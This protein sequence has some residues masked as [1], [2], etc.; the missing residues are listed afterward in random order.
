MAFQRTTSADFD[1]IFLLLPS[2]NSV[3]PDNFFVNHRVTKNLEVIGNVLAA[4]QVV[5][6]IQPD[7]FRSSQNHLKQF[8]I[9][10]C[11]VKILNFRFLSNFSQ[12]TDLSIKKSVNF[13]TFNL[14][15]LPNLISLSILNCTG[16][17]QWTVFP[18]FVKG[19]E[20][21]DLECN[22]LN[23]ETTEQ[24]LRYI[25]TGPS[26]VSLTNI[27]LSRNALT[28]IPRQLKSFANIKNMFFNDQREPGFGSLSYL[29]PLIHVEIYIDLSSCNITS[30]QPDA[31]KGLFP[32]SYINKPM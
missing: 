14:P 17:N 18:N 4:E 32:A 15:P 28:R 26:N 24:L 27:R 23:D 30:I 9:Y 20:Y 19:L 16:L 13:H 12:L 8:K 2:E 29:S 22:G 1:Q 31:L 7:A 10:S 21:L 25:M 6:E 5:L 11:D 3:I